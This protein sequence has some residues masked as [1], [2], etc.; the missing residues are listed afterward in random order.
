M[1]DPVDPNFARIKELLSGGKASMSQIQGELQRNGYSQADAEG[2]IHSAVGVPGAGGGAGS[3]DI[4]GGVGNTQ[5]DTFL[6]ESGIGGLLGIPGALAKG[7]PPTLANPLGPLGDLLKGMYQGQVKQT[8]DAQAS[9]SKNLSQGHYANALSD[10]IEGTPIIGR[11]LTHAVSNAYQNNYSGMLGDLVGLLG[12][13]ALEAATEGASSAGRTAGLSTYRSKLPFKTGDLSVEDLQKAVKAGVDQGF[14]AQ[15]LF[16]SGRGDTL[17]RVGRMDQPGTYLGGLGDQLKPYVTGAN[18]ALP[19]NAETAYGPLLN[20]IDSQLQSPAASGQELAANM[21]AEAKPGLLKADPK[22][23]GQIFD[24]NPVDAKGNP[25]APFT[26]AQRASLI[27]N[28]ATGNHSAMS[29]ADAHAGKQRLYDGLSDSAYSEKSAGSAPVGKRDALKLMAAGYKNAVNEVHPEA[30]PINDAVHNTI[31][32]KDALNAAAKESPREFDLLKNLVVGGMVGAAGG[33]LGHLAGPG[34]VESAG[35]GVAGAITL[36]ALQSPRVATQLAIIMG[37]RF[38]AVADAVA[39]LIQP[40]GY[41]AMTA[42]EA[43]QSGNDQIQQLFNSS[44]QRPPNK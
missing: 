35:A 19:V 8:G 21:L 36:K 11:P 10:F 25:V 12:P 7:S 15:S 18:G 4:G 26:A 24:D 5:D 31:N 29:V 37:K 17:A 13:K 33:G 6:G 30:A 44:A 42:G 3:P 2:L 20:R 28:W 27:R 32:L 22:I 9:A 1:A 43:A 38:P 40:T 34:I 41:T 14:P 23:M 39:P 16:A